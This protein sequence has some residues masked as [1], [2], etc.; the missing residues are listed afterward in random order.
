[1]AE[2]SLV[3]HPKLVFLSLLARQT[4]GTDS[5]MGAVFIGSLPLI[6]FRL[7]RVKTNVRR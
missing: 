4:Q 1:M 7:V 5:V 3:V 2:D 6:E